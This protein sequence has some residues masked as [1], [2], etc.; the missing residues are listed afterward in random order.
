LTHT[1]TLSRSGTDDAT[2]VTVA[3][4]PTLPAG[5]TP[6][7]F[8]PT[9]GTFDAGTLTWNVGDWPA[10]E[11]GNDQTL[12]IT[13]T[14]DATAAVCTGCISAQGTVSSTSGLDTDAANDTAIDPT[15]VIREFDLGL[16]VVDAPDPV[17]A[18]SGDSNLT[19]TFTLSRSGPSDAAD[20]EVNI[21]PS[22]PGGVTPVSFTPSVGAMNGL[23]WEVADTW[24]ADQ[25]GIDQ[26]LVIT[27]TVDSTAASCTDCVSAEGTVSASSGTDTNSANDTAVDP[28]SIEVASDQTVGFAT[29]VAFSNGNTGTVTATLTCNAGLP[30]SQEFDISESAGVTFTMSELPYT[31]EG[32]MCE[33]AIDGVESGYMV[34]ADANGTVGDSCMFDISNFAADGANTCVFIA[35]PMISEF[36]VAIDF[37]GVDDPSIEQDWVLDIACSPAS[38]DTGPNFGTVS[39]NL[40]GTGSADIARQFYADP[41]NDTDCTATLSG[42]ASAIEQDGP[43]TVEDIAV[44]DATS[45][46]ECTITATVF[47]EGIP[48]LS[49]YG[50]AIMALLMLGIGFVGFRRFV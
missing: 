47:F 17:L 46:D 5:V 48:T 8:V 11:N 43:C 2:G 1:F 14:V 31:T 37:V 22:L 3:V 42:L 40:T 10:T 13:L 16:T 21:V 45:A 18:G 36:V 32:T 49:Q 6:V 28:T 39:L 9:V 33:I 50:L 7:S 23:V 4:V 34:S 25:N 35:E 27:L 24:A 30:L 20:V 41:A 26:T 29:S 15:S 19:H 12:T 44:G 38:D